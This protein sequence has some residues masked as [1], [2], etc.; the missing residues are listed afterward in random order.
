MLDG[1]RV[2]LTA[3]TASFRV[4][5]FVGYQLTLP[6]PP[7][8]TIYGLLA[9]AKGE[10]VAP[11]GVAWFAYR[12]EYEGQAFDVEAITQ[13]ERKKPDEAPQFADRNVLNR[14]FLVWPRL[15]LYL[16]ADWADPFRRPR[17]QLLLGRTQDVATVQT[18]IDARLEP[19]PEGH[20]AG[21]LLPLELVEAMGGH[22]TV[23][24]HSLP[25]ALSAEPYRRRLGAHIFGVVD[26][27]GRPVLVR[28]D[29]W[30]VRDTET[31]TVL[32]VWRQEWIRE[33]TS[34]PGQ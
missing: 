32:P 28:A 34:R 26:A 2:V 10:W 12:L 3:Y 1:I 15:T 13:V 24:L 4:P 11:D 20:V 5:H 30:L 7:I 19:V 31:G 9:A 23:W 16:P 25:I 22:G 21:V 8:S 18:I 6:V 29:G 27:R 17:Y 14:Q 33:R